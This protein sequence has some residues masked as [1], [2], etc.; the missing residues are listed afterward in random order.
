M[1]CA[2]DVDAIDLEQPQPPNGIAQV[3]DRSALGPL[4]MEPLRGE[5]QAARFGQGKGGDH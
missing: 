2:H 1:R 5:S 3:P 4:P